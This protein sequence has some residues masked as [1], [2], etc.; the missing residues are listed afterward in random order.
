M[1]EYS[2]NECGKNFGNKKSHYINHK[3]KKYPCINKHVNV[4]NCSQIEN[5]APKSS[6]FLLDFT[7]VDTD[8]D[9]TDCDNNISNDIQKNI[10][11]DIFDNLSNSNVKKIICKYC[12]VIFTRNSN[13]NKH[14]KY[15]CKVKKR[16]DEE[17]ENIFKKLLEQENTIKNK[18]EQI[19]TLIGKINV[20]EEKVEKITKITSL[21]NNTNCSK[22]NKSRIN[23]NII[24]NNITNNSQNQTQTNNGIIFNL[25]NY[26]KEDL[27]KIDI[28]YFI[29]NIVKNNKV[30]GVKIPEEILKIIHFNPA[31]PELNNIYISDINREKCMIYDD[32]MWKLSP[33]D[34]IPEVIDKVVKF[35]Y[36]KDNQIRT[37]CPNNK[38]LIDRLNTINKYTKFNDTE[39]LEELKEEFI[40]DSDNDNNSTKKNKIKRCEEFQKKTY[41]VFKTTMYNEG[42]KI[43]KNKN[44]QIF[45]DS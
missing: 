32:G 36:N 42:L 17:K 3:N 34:K 5:F 4:P 40:L 12:N 44:L 41:N 18:D 39:Y 20:L 43:K 8:I 16:Q 25:V 26:G 22:I 28:K 33:D 21:N 15:N 13:L 45:K 11:N 30:S 35:S 1:V 6:H 31:Y 23:K 19:K 9:F 24:N 38:P 2:C 10:P 37:L 7:N 29:N 27:D 14:L